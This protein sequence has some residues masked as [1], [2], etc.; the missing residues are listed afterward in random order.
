MCTLVLQISILKVLDL[1]FEPKIAI[2]DSKLLKK[3]KKS[4]TLIF[5]QPLVVWTWFTPHFNRIVHITITNFN[6]GPYRLKF[7]TKNSLFGWILLKKWINSWYWYFGIHWSYERGL[8][9][10]ITIMCALLLLISI[11]ELLDLKLEPKIAIPGQ[12]LLKRWRNL[13][14]RYFGQGCRK[15]VPQALTHKHTPT[16]IHS[17]HMWTQTNTYRHSHKNK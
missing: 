12:K 16:H 15:W 3:W 10:I 6:I 7:W 14:Y 13:W 17:T 1:K 9:L 4:I 2:Y 11:F 5:R 8:P